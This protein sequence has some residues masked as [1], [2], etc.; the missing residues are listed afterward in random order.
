M[1]KIKIAL[2][3]FLANSL[4][5]R[6]LASYL[7]AHGHAVSCF[8][9]TEPLNISLVSSFLHVLMEKKISLIGISLVTD[10]YPSAVLLTK[11][12]KKKLAIPVIWGGAHVNVRPDEC[13]R[14]ADMICLGEGEEALLELAESIPP[15][16]RVNTNIKNIWFNSEGTVIKNELRPLVEDLDKYPFPDFDLNSQHILTERGIENFQEKHLRGEY[17]IMT[18]R[19]CPYGCAYCYNNYRKKHYEGKGRYLR[20][21]SIENAIGELVTAR[22]IFKSLKRINFWDDSFVARPLEEFQKFKFLYRERIGLPFFALIEPMAYDH[23]KIKLLRD[24]GLDSLQVGIQ[25]GS[26]RINREIYKRFVSNDTIFAMAHSIHALGIRAVFDII[27]NNPYETKS[28][29]RETIRMFLQFPGPLFLQGYNLIFYPGTD[30]T[31]RALRDGYIS[32]NTKAEDFSRIQSE[33]NSPFNL[34]GKSEISGRFYTIHYD[35][36]DKDYFNS[37]MLILG[38]RNIPKK[39]V[40][41]FEKSETPFK[42][43]L[44]KVLIKAYAAASRIKNG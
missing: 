21:R 19:G 34:T 41:F 24:A 20:A 23:N 40:L 6:S 17:S 27:F 37:V 9:C 38:L 25:S 8:F 31:E 35:S 12:I 3:S 22:K 16:G 7:K 42:A 36:S 30:L 32:L 13:L 18:S 29:L 11:E 14:H 39:A 5:I 10:D 2:V 33:Y 43:R 15:Q 4:N 1:G 26:S 28:D 44:L